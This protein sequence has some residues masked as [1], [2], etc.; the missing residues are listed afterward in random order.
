MKNRFGFTLVELLAVVVIL[1]IL[2]VYL[3]ALDVVDANDR[4]KDEV[5]DCVCEKGDDKTDNS[6][7]NC[8]LCIGN[9]L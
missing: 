2:S 6:I 9:L 7:K 5:D 3:D 4:C 8:I 1:G